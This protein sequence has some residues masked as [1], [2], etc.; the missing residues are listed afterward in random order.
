MNLFTEICRVGL[1]LTGRHATPS[2]ARNDC[3]P[4]PRALICARY[5]CRL[6]AECCWRRQRTLL[7]KLQRTNYN[8][9]GQSAYRNLIWDEVSKTNYSA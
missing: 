6:K 8:D 7:I 2:R 9:Y 3:G 4:T 5:K 1:R